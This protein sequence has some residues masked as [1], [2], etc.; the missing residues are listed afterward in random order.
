MSETNQ[1][2]VLIQWFEYMD[3]DDP[4]R[5][6]TMISK[7]FVMSVQFSKGDG[8]SAEFVGDRD[9]LVAYLAQREKSVLIHHIDAG[10][11]V[12]GVELSLGRTTR[13]GDFEASFNATAQLDSEGKV[14]R[15]LIARTPELS[16]S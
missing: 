2:P 8:Q 15:L 10:A 13:G 1:T 5:V 9:G 11:F 6:L 16:F 3:S 7:D 4:D 12:D 14:R